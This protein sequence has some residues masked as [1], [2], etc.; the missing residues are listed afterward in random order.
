MSQSQTYAGTCPGCDERVPSGDSCCYVCEDCG[1]CGPE[2]VMTDDG[3]EYCLE[4]LPDEE[5]D[6]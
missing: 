4:C 5:E 2:V 6:E 3:R 1:E